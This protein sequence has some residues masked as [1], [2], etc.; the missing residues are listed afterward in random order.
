M[1]LDL[2]INKKRRIEEVVDSSTEN[3]ATRIA[4]EIAPP[5]LQQLP[6]SPVSA[7]LSSYDPLILLIPTSITGKAIEGASPAISPESLPSPYPMT[8]SEAPNPNSPSELP[9]PGY[10]PANWVD[11]TRYH[12]N[13]YAGE[14]VLH[15]SRTYFDCSDVWRQDGV[16]WIRLRKVFWTNPKWKHLSYTDH[17]LDFV[18]D[19]VRCTSD[20]FMLYKGDVDMWIALK[21]RADDATMAE[22][23][24][25]A[26]PAVP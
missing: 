8:C 2:V 12:D 6:L 14:L 13:I 3:E 15:L 7:A 11:F 26:S 4:S 20:T 1:A 24:S 18:Q 5:S 22:P 19:P 21:P 25:S 16:S 10:N 23:S 17:F 9:Y